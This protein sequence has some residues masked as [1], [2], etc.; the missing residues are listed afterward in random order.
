MD[1]KKDLLGE[2]NVYPAWDLSKNEQ[3]YGDGVV[4]VIYSCR[5][6]KDGEWTNPDYGSTP[7]LAFKRT[8]VEDED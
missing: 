7:E 4:D 1:N 6:L 2:L 5:V 3:P 8:L